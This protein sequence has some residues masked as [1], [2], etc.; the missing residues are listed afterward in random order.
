[1]K[2]KLFLLFFITTTLF[3][4]KVTTAVDTN[5]NK[6]GAEFKLTLKTTVNKSDKV[7]FPNARNFGA[8]EVINSYKIDTVKNEGS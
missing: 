2:L 7:K 8:L 3:S 5:R 6:I 4:Q 1:M